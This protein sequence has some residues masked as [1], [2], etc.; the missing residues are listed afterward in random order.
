MNMS[1]QLTAAQKFS[2]KL[3]K[4]IITANHKELKGCFVKNISISYDMD[5]TGMSVVFAVSDEIDSP[6]TEFKCEVRNND[7]IL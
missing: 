4:Y 3:L 7:L 1:S 6:V 5:C 2:D